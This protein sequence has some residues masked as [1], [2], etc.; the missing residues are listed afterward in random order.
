M[1]TTKNQL[2]FK[3]FNEAFAR[4]DI[5]FLADQVTD[6]VV[7]RL[8]VEGRIIEGK[9][10]FVK[11][12]EEMRMDTVAIELNIDQ[13]ITHGKV[14]SVNGTMSMGTHTYAFCDVYQLHAHK[15]GKIKVMDSYVHDVS[16][17]K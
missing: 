8:H 13:L 17:M 4:S 7:W 16:S 1:V 9:E 6:D 12:L 15:D 5:A 2:F 10:N 14:A 3:E 11:K